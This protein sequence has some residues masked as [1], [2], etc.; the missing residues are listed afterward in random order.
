MEANWIDIFCAVLPLILFGVGFY[1]GL[2]KTLIHLVAWI[3][4]AVGVVYAPEFLNPFLAGNFEFSE[5]TV[6]ILSRVM[7]FLAP[8]LALRILGHFINKFVKRHFSLPNALAGGAFG[9]VKGLIPCVILLSTLH[10][11]P[12]AGDLEQKRNSSVAY[13]IYTAILRKTNVES[14][15]A[16]ARDSI[17]NSIT[18]KVNEAIDSSAARIS[19]SAGKAIREMIS[20][21]TAP[22]ER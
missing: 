2:A 8:F 14:G 18:D 19:N 7:G 13:A 20:D 15:L 10:L 21:T 17:Q 1:F 11:L 6:I 5:T 22:G 3:G 9:L 12:L 4:G 16:E